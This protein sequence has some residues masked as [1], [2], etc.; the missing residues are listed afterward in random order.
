[1]SDS[2][3][4]AA[5]ADVDAMTVEQAAYLWAGL[6]PGSFSFASQTAIAPRLAMLTA[7]IEKGEL[8][9]DLRPNLLA[10]YGNH[11]RSVVT[12]E[13]LVAFA[14][15]RGLR[16]PFLFPLEPLAASHSD[17]WGRKY[18]KAPPPVPVLERGRYLPPP[19][20]LSAGPSVPQA[21]P[22]PQPILNVE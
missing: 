19:A 8:Q 3:T 14:T 2:S 20:V 10:S 15:K 17:N 18:T 5:W 13:A 1:M 21:I 4:W 12:R 6:E 16:P 11:E 7:A 9:A 22:T